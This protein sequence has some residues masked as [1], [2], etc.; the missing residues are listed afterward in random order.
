METEIK[1]INNQEK[2]FHTFE[3]KTKTMDL[4]WAQATIFVTRV[5]LKVILTFQ[6]LTSLKT[7]TFVDVRITK[8]IV[9]NK[10]AMV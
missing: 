6:L 7:Q 2:Q 9:H 4:S 10:P 5:G 3:E 1:Q 8:M